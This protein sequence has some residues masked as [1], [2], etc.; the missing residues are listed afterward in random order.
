MQGNYIGVD[1][2]GN[3]DLGNAGQGVAIFT[4]AANNTI[5]GTAAGAGNVISGN[6][7]YGIGISASGATA[8]IV[9]GNLIGT[10]AAGTAGIANSKQ[11][12]YISAGAA[13]TVVGGTSAGAGN[14]IGYNTLDG[15]ALKS[16]AGS[17]TAFGVTRSSR[18][19]GSGSI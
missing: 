15:V 7:G 11:G 8:N 18:T 14:T 9:Q 19:A 13:N 1:A 10:N 4:S 6:D 16:D 12:V 17:G 2:T 3:V 5:G